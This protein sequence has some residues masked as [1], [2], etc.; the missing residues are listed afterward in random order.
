MIP[1]SERKCK[2]CGKKRNEHYEMIN[3]KLTYI[4]CGESIE[5]RW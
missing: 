5:D 2:S 3:N 1:D 4:A